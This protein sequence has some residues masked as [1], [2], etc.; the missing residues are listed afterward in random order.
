MNNQHILFRSPIDY[1]QGWEDHR[2][3]EEG[4]DVREGDILVCILASGDN[5]LNLLLFNPSKI[6]AF[7]VSPGQIYEMKLKLTALQYL[8]HSEFITLLGYRG[9]GFER[10][11]VFKSIE[12]RLDVETR[13]FWKKNRSMIKKGL[14]FQGWW[15]RYISSRRYLVKLLLGESFSRYINSTDPSERENIFEKH[16]NRKGLRILSKFF[17]GKIGTNLILFNGPSIRYLPRDFD[18]Y[19]HLWKILK[20]LFVGAGCRDNPYLYW[21]F[22][23]KILSDERFWQPY[24]RKENY[25]LLK[26]NLSRVKIIH[27]DL[28]SGLRSFESNKVDKVYASDIFDWMNRKQMETT[29]SEM[30][31]VTRHMG[32][33]LYFILNYDKGIPEK[34]Q[35]YVETDP[36]KNKSLWKKERVG[37]YSNVYL[38]EVNKKL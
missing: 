36:S 4:L 10:I 28:G 3:I 27:N 34:I 17:L 21:F 38:L 14:A 37:V 24:L 16:I 12:D 9:T 18:Y 33:I 31:R 35:K 25:P 2:V 22:T 1:A 29:L 11:E 23:G 7:D 15:E 6:Y 19:T 5:V 13:Y 8:N 26:R 32:R 20:H 30:V